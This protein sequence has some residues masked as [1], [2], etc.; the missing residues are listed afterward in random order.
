MIILIFQT[1]VCSCILKAISPI[2]SNTVFLV[3]GDC[4]NSF[5]ITS[6]CDKKSCR[7][8]NCNIFYN[9]KDLVLFELYLKAQINVLS[10]HWKCNRYRKSTFL[11]VT[12]V[13]ISGENKRYTSPNP[14]VTSCNF[15]N[16]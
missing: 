10:L 16:I 4:N 1:L 3:F 6:S 11:I 13:S 2:I 15:I 5:F 7:Y 12:A 9:H 14:N 8:R